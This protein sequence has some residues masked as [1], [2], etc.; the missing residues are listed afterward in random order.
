MLS[1]N[2]LLPGLLLRRKQLLHPW[3]T[4]CGEDLMLPLAG[5]RGVVLKAI[6]PH[7]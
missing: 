2:L 3:L 7:M 6:C 1:F 5:Q 4:D